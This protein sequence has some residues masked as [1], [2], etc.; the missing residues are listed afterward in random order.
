MSPLANL[1]AI[2]VEAIHLV[3]TAKPQSRAPMDTVVGGAPTQPRRWAPSH[4]RYQVV[5]VSPEQDVVQH[6][7]RGG[8][9]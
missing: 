7:G 5:G 8:I 1:E 4:R 9:I 6:T 2:L 3:H